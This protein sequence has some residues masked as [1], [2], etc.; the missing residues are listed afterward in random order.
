MKL[1]N[2]WSGW[3][4]AVGVTFFLCSI[5]LFVPGQSVE[6]KNNP[7]APSP[8]GNS[9]TVAVGGNAT[10]IASINLPMIRPNTTVPPNRSDT[11]VMPTVVGSR[12][13]LLTEIYRVGIED[14]LYIKI[15]NAVSQPS[16]TTVRPDGTIDFPLAGENIAVVGLTPEEIGGKLARSIK[17]FAHTEVEVAVR[18]YASHTITVSG[19]V[20]NPGIKNLRREAVPLFTV[21]AEAMIDQFTNRVK[22]EG[23][24]QNLAI[25]DLRDLNTGNVLVFPG[26]KIDYS[27]D[28]VRALGSYIVRRSRIAPQ[29]YS[30]NAGLTLLQ[31]VAAASGPSSESTKA[32]IRRMN[33]GK[34]S[35]LEF[36]L[37]AIR[38]GK[39]SDPTIEAGDTIEI[40]D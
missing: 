26:S 33:K 21:T 13:L 4:S 20:K 15:R 29:Q 31:A 2:K 23:P 35:S 18:E 24:E 19:N 9:R 37:R 7:Y 25:Y 28:K 6:R 12:P 34:A 17:L 30:L 5:C 27:I 14:V 32:T 10:E 38:S 1:A 39:L 8:A 40:R 11:I 22:I 16:Y 3:S 36:D